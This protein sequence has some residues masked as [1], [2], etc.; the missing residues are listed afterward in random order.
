MSLQ[1]RIDQQAT[2][3]S[4]LENGT[5]RPVPPSIAALEAAASAAEQAFRKS[6]TLGNRLVLNKAIADL[7]DAR[8][9]A[10]RFMALWRAEANFLRAIYTSGRAEAR[11]S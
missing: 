3:Q 10:G 9:G 8:A 2:E 11:I 7:R 1:E 5:A 6:P 4:A